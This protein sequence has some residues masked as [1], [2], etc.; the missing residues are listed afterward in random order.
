MAW[1]ALVSQC[2]S[3]CLECRPLVGE[4]FTD[5]KRFRGEGFSRWIIGLSTFSEPLPDATCTHIAITLPGGSSCQLFHIHTIGPT[6][7]KRQ[8]RQVLET[9]CADA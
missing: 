1:I 3:Q 7:T 2:K 6:P 4:E 8:L 9:R 5:A